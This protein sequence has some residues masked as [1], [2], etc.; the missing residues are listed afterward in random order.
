[1][2]GQRSTSI[3]TEEY[4]L[5]LQRLRQARRASGLTQAEVAERL[6]RAQSLVSKMETGEKRV[7]VVELRAFCEAIGASLVEFVA[8]FD[9]ALAALPG[10]RLPGSEG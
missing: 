6:R 4:A 7:D 1:V 2:P 3:W 10:E 9:A 8:E 5:F